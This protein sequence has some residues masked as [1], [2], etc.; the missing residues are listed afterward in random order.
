VRRDEPEE[1]VRWVCVRRRPATGRRLLTELGSPGV[2]AAEAERRIAR[3]EETV[4]VDEN[5]GQ[6]D[7]LVAVKRE[8]YIGHALPSAH[9]TALVTR[10]AAR[11]SGVA[12]RLMD[13]AVGFARAQGY[14]GV[15]LTC[16]LTPAREA[17]H[18]F[19][20]SLGFRRTSYRYWLPLEG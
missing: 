9:V 6:L 2:D 12:R 14:A 13:A 17:A 15:E 19:Y 5:G 1:G 20:P 3:Q 8:L 4:F 7:G 18:R 16:G 10:G 11:R